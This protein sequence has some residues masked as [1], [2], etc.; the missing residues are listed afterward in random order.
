MN[1]AD[2]TILDA[3]S[4]PALWRPWFR[5]AAS[6]A[7]WFAFFKALFGLPMTE[8]DLAVYRQCTGRDTAPPDGFV[9]AW[10]VCGRRAGKSF[11]LALTAVFL[12]VFRDWRPHLSPGEIGTIKIIAC[13]RRQARVIHRYC[14]ALLTR[15]PVLAQM[16][17]RDGDDEIELSNGI[18]IEIQT[19]SFRSVRGYTV[20]AGLCD[21]ISFWRSDETSANPDT[22]ILAALRPAM[23]TIPGA[24]LLAASSPYARRGA[25]WQAFR[26]H[27]G[28]DGPALVWRADTRTM[29]P[30]VPQSVID[31]AIEADPASAAA[32]YGAEF[33]S[34]IESYI[35]REVVEAV[36]VPGRHELPP[37]AGNSYAAFCDPSGGSADAMTLAI[38]HR[39][40]ASGSGTAVI[41]AIREVR[42]P[43]D[44]ESVVA[45]FAV[46]L[47]SYG[48]AEVVGDKYGGDWPGS[49][50][51]EH[52][53]AYRAAEKPKS[54]L[55]RELLPLLN[56]GKVELLD[57]A[58]L[59]AQL[60]ALER[61]TA[62]GGR[63]SIDHPP[64]GH[65]DLANV[66]AGAA[67]GIIG[68]V[69]SWALLARKIRAE[70]DAL[71]APEPAPA[72]VTPPV[73]LPTPQGAPGAPRAPAAHDTSE[74]REAE[75]RRNE[76]IFAELLRAAGGNPRMIW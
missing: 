41:D 5:D 10:L 9:E 21:E 46:L 73:T 72:G 16:I 59:V 6:W 4:N 76:A 62:R 30:T 28:N 68:E 61:R 45:E 54:D 8:A 70:R 18:V 29:N 43:F 32:E 53:I 2:T 48:L 35:A 52:G 26:R 40:G 47:K 31:E 71:Q 7:P 27:F 42:P 64:G 33:R 65:D 51:R 25:L 24:M 49:R 63:D 69:S 23:A 60:C 13:D 34:D 11:I 12:A 37:I 75:R 15:V 44:P 3:I 17:E 36:V 1:L 20:I 19:A 55:Y 67:V 66:I 58:R 50:F 39:E 14:R 22:E 38:A 57:H 74:A 56:A